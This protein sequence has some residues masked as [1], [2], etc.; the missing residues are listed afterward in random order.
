MEYGNVIDPD[1]NSQLLQEIYTL[2]W[3]VEEHINMKKC[4]IGNEV[5]G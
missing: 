5:R 3:D 1:S 4:I 2:L